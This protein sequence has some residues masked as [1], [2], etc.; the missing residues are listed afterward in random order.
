LDYKNEANLYFHEVFL[1]GSF[2]FVE[3][4]SSFPSEFQRRT[5]WRA[6]TGVAILILG[7][8]LVGLIWLTSNVLGYLQPVFVPLAVAGIIAYL[9]DPVVRWL[10]NRGLSRMKGIIAVFSGFV[11]F[12][13]ILLSF[14]GIKLSGQIQA[15]FVQDNGGAYSD[16]FKV[17]SLVEHRKGVFGWIAGS[18]YKKDHEATMRYL[19]SGGALYGPDGKKWRLVGDGHSLQSDGAEPSRNLADFLRSDWSDPV[20]IDGVD[21]GRNEV[22]S[23]NFSLT[24]GG[25]LLSGFGENTLGWLSDSSG[26]ILGFFGVV[27]GLAMVPIYLYY[28]LK[29]SEGIKQGW[30]GY[31][32]LRASQFKTSVIETL[33]EINGYLISFFRGQVLV[34]FIDGIL[35]GVALTIYGLNYGLLIGVCM[36]L[37]GIIPYIGNII[38]LVPAC[39]IAANQDLWGLPQWGAVLG[40]VLIFVTVQQINSLVTAPKIVGDSVGLHPMTVI[41]SMLFW[42]LLLGG[43]LGALL[44]VPLTAAVKVVFKRYVWDR[45]ATAEDQDRVTA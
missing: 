7:A 15:A 1:L 33:K 31:V 6:L 10:Q 30:E 22:V 4:N 16:L 43:L 19:E 26:K 14:V 21:D 18:L 45:Q 28:F 36:T 8:L 27:L 34:A 5:M 35:V 39:F 29:E 40:V 42:S 32:P 13:G 38:C 23:R 11:L 20:T 41:F 2:L 9:L 3:D 44:A 37:L 12:F 17:D 24:K 25:A